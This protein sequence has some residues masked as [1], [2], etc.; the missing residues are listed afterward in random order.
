MTTHNSLPSS[1]SRRRFL[2]QSFAFSALAATGSLHHAFALAP[3]PAAH[4]VLALG[5][6]GRDKE[7]EDQ[8]AVARGMAYYVLKQ[9]LGI[10]CLFLLGDSWYGPLHGG[11]D[12]QRWHEQFEAM[13]PAAT[14]PGPAYSIMGNHDYQRMPLTVNKRDT[15]L[16]YAR[17]GN[18][19]WTQ[20]ALWYSFELPHMK[21]IALD[22]NVHKPFKA[23]G[24]DF[25]LTEQEQAAQLAWFAAE[26]DKPT[27][28]PFTV[29]MGHHPIFSNGPHGDHKVLLAEWEPLLRKHKIPL[30]LAGHD[31]DLQHLEFEGH[32]TSFVSSGAG[33]AELYDLKITEDKRGPFAGKVYGFTHLEST[34]ET[35]TLRHIDASGDVLHA[36]TRAKNGDV[37]LLT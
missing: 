5:D 28:A 20:P 13:Y 29:V 19:R 23:D 10:D 21:V 31:H 1:P 11:I 7:I 26:L 24:V 34:P 25:T 12:S 6:W 35:L 14:F 8:R 16:A 30:Y 22:S 2:R 3:D 32:P 18:T 33:G 17:R 9:R 37:R 15:E 4:H 36:F 27:R